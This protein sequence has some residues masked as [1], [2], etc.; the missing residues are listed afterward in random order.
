MADPQHLA[1]LMCGGVQTALPLVG[2]PFPL[3]TIAIPLRQSSISV[4]PAVQGA[5]ARLCSLPSLPRRREGLGRAP[6]S[7]SV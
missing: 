2:P 4:V 5:Q 3:T 7:S 6:G 1:V